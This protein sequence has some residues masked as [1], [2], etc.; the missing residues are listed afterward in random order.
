MSETNQPSTEEK[1]PVFH[2]QRIYMK[3]MSF[4][5]PKTPHIFQQDWTPDVQLEV[6]SD[7][8]VLSNNAYEVVLR[9]TVTAK[10]AEEVAFLCEIQQA[11][12]FTIEG[13]PDQNMESTLGAYCPNILYPYAR[14]SVSSLVLRGSF[15]QLNLGPINFDALLVAKKQKLAKQAAE[16]EQA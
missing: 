1:P 8:T 10:M 3:D 2:I 9:L 15:P 11:G 6:T 12:I 4:E 5:T 13:I 16:A 14:E 7:H